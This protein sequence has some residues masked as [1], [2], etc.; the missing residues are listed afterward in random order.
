MQ[1]LENIGKREEIISFV[2]N[3]KIDLTIVGPELPLAEGIVDSF[4]KHKFML[5]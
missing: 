3:K 1:E 4:K 2:K 5:N